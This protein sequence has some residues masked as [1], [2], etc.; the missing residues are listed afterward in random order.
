MGKR[1]TE[2]IMLSL[3]IKMKH[4]SS[5]RETNGFVELKSKKNLFTMDFMQGE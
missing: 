2:N 3:P 4:V 5:S 1:K